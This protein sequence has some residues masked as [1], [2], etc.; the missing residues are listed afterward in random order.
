MSAFNRSA[1]I[2]SI[3]AFAKGLINTHKTQIVLKIKSRFVSNIYS[4][5]RC[6]KKYQPTIEAKPKIATHK[7]TLALPNGNTPKHINARVVP[8][9]ICV[10][11]I[12]FLTMCVTMQSAVA[13]HITMVSQNT[14][15]M[16]HRAALR[17][18]PSLSPAVMGEEP[19]PASFV[20]RP[21]EMPAL[22]DIMRPE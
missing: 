6:P 21:L 5:P 16:A 18:L 10:P 4:Y 1:N 8:S 13:R 9:P 7:A 17:Q 15:L 14:V 11:P 22:K 12:L 19:S 2:Q 3:S 20:K